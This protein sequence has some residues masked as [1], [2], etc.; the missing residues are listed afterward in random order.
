MPAARNSFSGAE[1]GAG[2]EMDPQ[3]SE[4]CVS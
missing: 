1:G 2:M 3:E 4:V